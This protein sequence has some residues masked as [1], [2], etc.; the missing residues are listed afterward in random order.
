MEHAKRYYYAMKLD[1]N[2]YALGAILA[3]VELVMG[4]FLNIGVFIIVFLSIIFGK[5]FAHQT[6]ASM[7]HLAKLKLLSTYI[8]LTIIGFVV[9]KGPLTEMQANLANQPLISVLVYVL[10]AV[11]YA[12]FI[13][14]LLTLGSWLETRKKTKAPSQ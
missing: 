1:T 5:M 10:G 13:Y 9:W 2:P 8:P 4:I 14:L 7:P 11:V 12:A 6:G 3:V